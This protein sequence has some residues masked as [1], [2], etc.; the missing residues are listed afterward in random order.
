[1]TAAVG[2]A[3]GSTTSAGGASA[4]L[5]GSAGAA[6]AGTKAEDE[7]GGQVFLASESIRQ[8]TFS[9]SKTVGVAR[10]AVTEYQYFWT[11]KVAPGGNTISSNLLTCAY[12]EPNDPNFFKA[13]NKPVVVYSHD[14]EYRKVASSA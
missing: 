1:V 4:V 10:E 14:F 7:R 13:A 5:A 2:A 12:L 6:A 9:A 11:H 8:V 3:A